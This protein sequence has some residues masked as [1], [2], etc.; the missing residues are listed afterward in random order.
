MATFYDYKE[1]VGVA[2]SE[3]TEKILTSTEEEPKRVLRLRIYE[4]TSTRQNNAVVRVYIERERVAEIPIR[5]FLDQ[6]SSPIYPL[7]AGVIELGFELPIGQSLIVG[8]LSGA[9]PSNVTFV[10][11]YEIAG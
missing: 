5:V 9:T 3:V 6:A 1:V 4:S 2:N 7:G 11:E 10:V 8:H